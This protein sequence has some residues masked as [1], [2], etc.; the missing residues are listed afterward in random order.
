V[1]QGF[2]WAQDS[3]SAIHKTLPDL[4]KDMT[5]VKQ[6]VTAIKAEQA[7][8]KKEYAPPVNHN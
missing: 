2:K 5:T 8:Y 6:D 4:Q 3:N 7:R 1:N